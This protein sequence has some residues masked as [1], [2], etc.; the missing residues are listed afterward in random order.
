MEGDKWELYMPS[1]MGYGDKG[2]PPTIPAKSALV[3]VMELIKI[4]GEKV[5]AIRCDPSDANKGSRAPCHLAPCP[6]RSGCHDV[7]T[8]PQL[9]LTLCPSSAPPLHTAP[10]A[11]AATRRS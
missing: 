3:F 1:D 5:E 8:A 9:C 2:M 7:R 11:A 4:N 10:H 6:V